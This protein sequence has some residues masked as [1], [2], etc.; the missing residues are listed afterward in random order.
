MEFAIEKDVPVFRNS[1]KFPF[2][3][4]EVGDSFLAPIDKAPRLRSAAHNYGRRHNMVFT[5]SKVSDTEF[6][7]WRIA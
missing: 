7:C 2:G 3:Q 1:M 6:R 5:V 4:M